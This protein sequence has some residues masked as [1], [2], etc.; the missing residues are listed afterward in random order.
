M[1]TK[2][3]ELKVP[4]WLINTITSI[5]VVFVTVLIILIGAVYRQG[6]I[7]GR[8]IEQHDRLRIDHESDKLNTRAMI[9][10]LRET[11]ADRRDTDRIYN[12]LDRIEDH[13][14]YLK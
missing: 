13:L 8:M 12:Q 11:K 2:C 4:V 3:Y 9:Q 1:E 5:L 14:K 6:Q 7:Q 10:D